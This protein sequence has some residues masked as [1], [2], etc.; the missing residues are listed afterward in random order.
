MVIKETTQVADTWIRRGTDNTPVNTYYQ[1][2]CYV[3]L[4]KPNSHTLSL[5]ITLFPLSSRHLDTTLL[6]SFPIQTI[7]FS[8][9]VMAVSIHPKLLI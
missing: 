8:P 7:Q 5:K 1:A 2:L 4:V 3:T 9:T 6:N